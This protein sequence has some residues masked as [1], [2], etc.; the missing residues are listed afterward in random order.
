MVLPIGVTPHFSVLMVNIEEPT[1]QLSLEESFTTRG[2]LIH[3]KR[4]SLGIKFHLALMKVLGG[5]R[6]RELCLSAL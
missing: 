6:L 2:N 5:D 3:Q 4:V 1:S